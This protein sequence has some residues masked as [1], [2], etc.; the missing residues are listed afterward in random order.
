MTQA[1]VVDDDLD[2]WP[3]IRHSAKAA[4]VDTEIFSNGADALN[5]LNEKKSRADVVFLDL[6]MAPLDGLTVAE[7]IRRNEEIHLIKPPVKII[8]LTAAHITDAINRVADRV[9]VDHII[10]KP[11]DYINLFQSVKGASA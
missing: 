8:F 4:G 2:I 7:E 3:I 5:Y 1:V 9:G 10:S 6:M 11:C